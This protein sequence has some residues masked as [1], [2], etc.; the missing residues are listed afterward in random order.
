[1][2]DNLKLLKWVAFIVVSV[3]FATSA[4]AAPLPGAVPVG[5]TIS[6][7]GPAAAAVAGIGVWWLLRKK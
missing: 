7:T 1:M 4:S 3:V 5:G 2:K 6:L